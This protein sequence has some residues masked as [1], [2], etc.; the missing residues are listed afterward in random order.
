VDH[1]G[2]F[3]LITQARHCVALTGAG[4]SV[5]SGIRDFRGKNGLYREMDTEKIFDIDY[6][7]QDPAYFYRTAGSFV[8]HFDEKAPS[9]VHQVLAELE[10]RG[11]LQAVITQNIDG[12]HQRAGS[13][14]VIELHGSPA[15]HYCLRCPGIRMGFPEAAALVKAGDLPRCPRCGRVLKPAITFFGEPLPLEA[16]R[17][18]EAE[19]QEAGLMLILG[20]SLQVSP[21]S[22]LPQTT[23]RS[24]GSL[25]IVNDMPTP[26]DPRATLHFDDLEETFQ[27]LAA[28]LAH[29]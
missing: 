2:L 19:A 6:F 7:E 15:L 27:G 1:T 9:L 18:A 8:Y 12:L 14:R 13:R 20:T 21:A 25:V 10:N 23:L 17:E 22:D 28:L 3:R 26:L 11:L 24:G 5:L 29:T 16:H 4:V